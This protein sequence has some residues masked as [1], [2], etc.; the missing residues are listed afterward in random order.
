[1]HWL[2]PVDL[3]SFL[4]HSVISCFGLLFG[5]TSS[6][7]QS[8]VLSS[9]NWYKLAVNQTGVYR[10]DTDF[11]RK[12]GIDPLSVTPDQI[13][14]FGNKGGMLPQKND[15]AFSGHLEESAIWVQGESDGKFDS[16]DAVYFYAEGPNEIIFDSLK[17]EY[18]HQKNSY[19]DT[20]YYFLNLGQSNGLRIKKTNVAAGVSGKTVSQFEDYWYHESDVSNLLKSGREW[21]GEYLESAPLTIEA[22]IPG[23]VPGSEIKLRTSAIGSA[24]VTTRFL[25]QINGKQ[26]GENTIGTVSTNTYDIKGRRSDATHTANAG[27]SPPNPVTVGIGYDKNGQSTAQAYLNY[28]A[29]HVKRTLRSYDNQQLYRFLPENSDTVTYHFQDL[30]S[31]WNLWNVTDPAS[32]EIMAE[33]TTSASLAIAAR[34]GKGTRQLLGFRLDQAFTPI[35]WQSVKNQNIVSSNTPDLLIVTPAAWEIEAKRL[36]EF[37][38]VNDGL[39]VVVVTTEQIYNEYA[40]G[41]PDVSAIRNY[42]RALYRKKTG[43]L[44]Y[45]LLF[46]D[47]TFDYKNLLNNQTQLQRNN[48]VPVYESYESLNPVYT[49]SSDDYFGFME[50]GEGEWTESAAGDHT[51]DIGVGRLP[52]KSFAEAQTIVNKLINYNS[53]ESKSGSWK[54]SIRFVADDGDGNIHQSHADQLARLVQNDFLP[55]RL[56]IDAFPQVT[57]GEGQKAAQVNNAIRKS[58]DEGTLILNYTGH[59]GVSG[60]AE[61]QVLTLADMQSVRGMNNLPL[62]F[63]ATCDFGRYDDPGIVSGAEL[64][65]LSPRGAAIGAI[66]T[67]RP[68]YSSTNFTLSKAFYESLVK[69]GSRLK[70]GD[71]FRETK[72]K[73][74]SGSLN[75]NFTL[76]ADPSM[77]LAKAQKQIRWTLQPDTLRALQK[78]SLQGEIYNPANGLTDNLFTG[79]ASIEIYDKQSAFKTLGNEGNPESY[80]EFRTRL[81]KGS[82][83]VVNGKFSCNFTMPKDID[84]RTGT[85]RANIYA[86]QTGNTFSD[87]AAQLNVIVGGSVQ[88]A[89]DRTPPK[90]AAYLDHESFKPGD[91]VG[92]SPVLYVNVSDE[93]GINISDAGIGHGITLTINDTLTMTLNDYFTADLDDYRSGTVRYP[94]ENMPAG[95]YV[96]RLKVWDSYNNLS[97]IAFDFQVGI[98]KGIRFNALTIY[99]NPFHENFSFELIHDRINEDVEIIFSIFLNNG[100]RLSTFQKQY[101]NS[102]PMLKEILSTPDLGENRIPYNVPLLYQMQIRSLKDNSS[103]QRSGKLI[104]SP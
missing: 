37:R 91:T 77:Q 65:V 82:V 8:S 26:I 73:A 15:P 67:T 89:A 97:E 30:A 27:A 52:V 28:V 13:R 101:Y 43:K 3:R 53:A 59:G 55:S 57:T 42:A 17:A 36:A 32:P 70:A 48:W 21:W 94:L 102:E 51:V 44:K 38:K 2:K 61:E 50:D 12:M 1:M 29:L 40:A 92:P 49:F 45:L 74:L 98:L 78:V 56:F 90:L 14:I 35:S 88:P 20:S 71:I 104:R 60:W 84:Y 46:G 64:M 85:G 39:E 31:G 22:N 66:S 99:P 18:R 34:N 11:L 10:I 81:F 87:A 83:K 47:A 23:I 100:Q 72:N 76:L 9:G 80:A 25:W 19:T 95:K 7:Q 58:I 16:N 103:D 75:R 63:T 24:Q 6:A 4:V 41:K 5:Y 86:Y 33:N 62:L 79:I 93:N 96:I 68:V 69:A 54:N